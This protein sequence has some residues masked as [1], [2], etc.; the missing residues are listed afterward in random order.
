[1]SSSGRWAVVAPRLAGD[2]REFERESLSRKSFDARRL[3]KRRHRNGRLDG[4]SG[5]RG[6][7]R[8]Q[9]YPLES[10]F[11]MVGYHTAEMTRDVVRMVH[12]QCSNKSLDGN[13]TQRVGMCYD[14]DIFLYSKTPT[15]RIWSRID[16]LPKREKAGQ[17]PIA[18][19][20]KCF[21]HNRNETTTLMRIVRLLFAR[22]IGPCSNAR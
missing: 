1:M 19:A 6:R 15:N 10:T 13:N 12:G 4:H 21:E 16:Q 9:S 14:I 17:T 7:H 2:G 3:P 20:C 11:A 22:N 5:I 8:S 18:W